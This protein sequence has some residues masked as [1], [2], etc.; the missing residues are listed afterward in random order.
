MHIRCV[1][2]TCFKHNTDVIPRPACYHS[3]WYNKNYV[4]IFEFVIMHT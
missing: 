1:C 2:R 3:F 4:S